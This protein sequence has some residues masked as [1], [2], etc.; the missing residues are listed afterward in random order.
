MEKGMD[1]T[2]NMQGDKNGIQAC[3]R[4]SADSPTQN[5]AEKMRR[6]GGDCSHSVATTATPCE[7]QASECHAADL[8]HAP[9]QSPD[10]LTA[11]KACVV[12]DGAAY[13]A[14]KAGAVYAL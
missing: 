13:P 4:L 1:F 5:A 6:I 8:R 3:R 7:W 10:T 12:R 11:G 2:E 14:A 9:G